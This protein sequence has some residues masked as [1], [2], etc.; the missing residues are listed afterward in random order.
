VPIIVLLLGLAIGTQI[1]GGAMA[2]MA[3][4]VIEEI[5]I[6]AVIALALTWCI[7]RIL[8]FAAK[9]DWISEHWVEIPVV[10][11]AA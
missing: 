10:A 5:G 8:R 7:I 1:E 6:G 9:H 4:V 3:R 2:H 11:L